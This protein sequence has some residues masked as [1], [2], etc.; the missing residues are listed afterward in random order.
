MK[1]IAL[2]LV[3]LLAAA[4]LIAP[5]TALAKDATSTTHIWVGKADLFDGTADGM[6]FGDPYHANDL[7]QIRWSKA[8]EI[9][10]QGGAWSPEA[11]F[12]N[13][14]NGMAPGGT[15]LVW[16]TTVRWV[17]LLLSD[18]PYWIEGGVAYGSEFEI[19]TSHGIFRVAGPEHFWG[20]H[21]H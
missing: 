10:R 17:G 21:V 14:W 9:G 7:L 20:V 13:L 16:H 5:A 2:V 18:S 4:I 15:G 3:V 11:W 8:Y 12:T 1:R 6:L 19:V